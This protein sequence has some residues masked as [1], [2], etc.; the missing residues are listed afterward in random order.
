MK[1][2]FDYL[3]TP[4]KTISFAISQ[5][6]GRFFLMCIL[7][8]AGNACANLLPYFFKRIADQIAQGTGGVSFHD[9]MG[10]FGLVA[11]VL[12]TQEILFRT[13]HILETYIA[14]DGFRHLTTSLYE[15]LIKR[16]TSYFEDKFSGDLGRRIEQVG[17]GTIYFLDTFPWHMGWIICGLVVSGVLFDLIHPYVFLT[18]ASWFVI[19]VATSLPLLRWHY[20]ASKTVAASHAHLSGGIIDALSNV[21]LIHSF[22]AV[23]YEQGLNQESVHDLVKTERKVRWIS[24]LNK[25][26]Q[27]FSV[28]L[29]GSS[30]TL[31]SIFLFSRGQFTVGDFVVVAATI[32]LLVGVI[33]NFGDTIL[34]A[35]K[36]YGQL[37]DAIAHLR[38]RQE[39]LTGGALDTVEN[40]TSS[41]TF[42]DIL[43]QYP[44]GDHPVLKKFSLH[45]EQG[46]HLGIVGPSGAGKS[47]LVKLLLRQYEPGEGSIS[48][49]STPTQNLTLDTFNKLIS[50]V[51]QDT[52]LFH[53]TL[54]ENIHYANPAASREAVLEASMRAHAHEFIIALPDGYETK[55]GERGIK[56]SGGQRQRIAL[57]RAILKNAPIL[58]L[59]EAT[60]SL[61]SESESVVQQALSDLFESHTVIAIAHRLSTLRAMDRIVVMDQGAIIESGNPRDLLNNEK[62]LFKKMWEHQKNGFI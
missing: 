27:G 36:E 25:F 2:K 43:F 52:S 7:V 19:F 60:S 41:V 40:N 18:F 48:I 49:G 22:G 45:I 15:G 29:L 44:A 42:Q 39:Q 35:S 14:P 34:H 26:Q 58:V 31:V 9:L 53:R 11:A 61:D 17:T 59:D 13:G 4:F 28:F 20:R 56:L 33:W 12:V 21:S 23:A 32:P 10:S 51:P 6:R 5:N 47:T 38:K 1:T 54:F 50:Y 37:S 55:V 30:L 8:V 16:P 57:A 46:E 62:S 24:V 3:Q